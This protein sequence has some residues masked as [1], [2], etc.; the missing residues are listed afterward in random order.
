MPSKS[1]AREIKVGCLLYDKFRKTFGIVTEILSDEA[2]TYTVCWS[3]NRETW[4]FV[5]SIRI[6]QD[7][8]EILKESSDGSMR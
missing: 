6:W 4:A 8:L 7:E 1:S 2:E 5:A 3:D